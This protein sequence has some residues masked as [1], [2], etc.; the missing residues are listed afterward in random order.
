M[1][2]NQKLLQKKHKKIQQAIKQLGDYQVPKFF[3]KFLVDHVLFSM[4]ITDNDLNRYD[5]TSLFF[6]CGNHNYVLFLDYNE[7]LKILPERVYL[8]LKY[9]QE[10]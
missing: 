4:L 10:L 6:S 7:N 3:Y 2:Y 1:L 5:E 9:K 8:M